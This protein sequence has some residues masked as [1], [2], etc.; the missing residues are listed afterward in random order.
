MLKMVVLCSILNVKLMIC[1]DQALT[2]AILGFYHLFT[3]PQAVSN[4]HAHIA[5]V[6]CVSESRVTHH[7]GLMV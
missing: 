6:L 4:M 5:T 2:A 7:L 3:A 1:L